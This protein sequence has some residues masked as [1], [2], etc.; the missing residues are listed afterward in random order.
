MEKQS[1]CN[2]SIEL[3]L[4]GNYISMREILYHLFSRFSIFSTCL[5]LVPLLAVSLVYL[6]PQKYEATAKILLRH[7]DTSSFSFRPESPRRE[8]NIS[9]QSVVEILTSLPV[10]KRVVE[11]EKITQEEIPQ[12]A[13]KIL[14]RY[15]VGLTKIFTGKKGTE[16]VAQASS[17]AQLAKELR[18]S[19]Y[20]KITDKGQ[21]GLLYDDELIEVRV[22]FLNRNTVAGI[23]NALC[24]EFINEYYRI[25]EEDA[26]RIY[27]YLDRQVTIAEA[28]IENTKKMETWADRD[29]T[30]NPIVARISDQIAEMESKLFR[31]RSTYPDDAVEIKQM[32]ESLADARIR[33]QG[34]KTRESTESVLTTLKE[35]RLQAFLIL[36]AYENRLIP[37]SIVEKAVTPPYS[38][39]G[40]VMRYSLAGGIGLLAGL[41]LGFALV[42]FLSVID[43]R[44][45]TPWDVEKIFD[46][47]IIGSIM[48]RRHLL[49]QKAMFSDLSKVEIS[50][51]ILETLSIIDLKNQGNENVLMVTGVS[52]GEG[53]TT[54]AL[55][56]AC[57]LANDRRTRV[58]LVDADFVHQTLTGGLFPQPEEETPGLM[59]VLMGE[60][61]LRHEQQVSETLFPNL[62]FLSAG[63]VS[64]RQAIGFYR[65]SLK[66][67]MDILRKKYDLIIIDTPGM[68]NSVDTI[69][70]A[71]E[72]DHILMVLKSGATRKDPLLRALQMLH[73]DQEKLIGA[74]LNFRT[75]PVPGIFYGRG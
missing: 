47:N 27:Q 37:I 14:L 58:L 33:L 51:A 28:N 11:Q 74:L 23:T 41:C 68:L 30:M 53:K 8:T 20:P 72:A 43:S 9:S 44:L 65:K 22:R 16:N 1:D 56:V 2:R 64:Q 48:G 26:R 45:F 55:Q 54:V 31:L 60:A 12:P 7:N 39:M 50:N 75:Y 40:N 29:V 67:T 42:M 6:I 13:Y 66:M 3:G 69:L 57:A 19:I 15:F 61:D 25:F 73:R 10:C 49:D 17:T 5:L 59:D 21:A 63:K 35:K 36:Q 62:D 34:Y 46:I 4:K 70:F 24:H 18:K 71:A 52:E 38:P 32:K